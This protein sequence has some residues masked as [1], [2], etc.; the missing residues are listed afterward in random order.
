MPFWCWQY[1]K[2]KASPHLFLEV[3]PK[4]KSFEK[5][6]RW[7]FVTFLSPSW[8]SLSPLKGHLT[9]PKRSQRITRSKVFGQVI[10]EGDL[11]IPSHVGLVTWTQPL[12][13]GHVWTKKTSQKGH[14]QHAE[15]PGIY[16][17][18]RVAPFSTKTLLEA[19]FSSQI[20]I[21]HQPR[22][23]WNTG[24]S[25]TKPPFGVRSCE[26]AI[27]WPDDDVFFQKNQAKFQ[28]NLA[29]PEGHIRLLL[30]GRP[31]TIEVQ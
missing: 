26:V 22:F 31:R 16:M 24:I 13:S 21:F 25:L 4:K 27:I 9:I 19:D 10:Q 12:I 18:L 5:K 15:L 6:N 20:I 11:F 23:P 3:P 2:I 30:F 14:Q 1:E 7:F 17:F 28:W 8:R 29:L